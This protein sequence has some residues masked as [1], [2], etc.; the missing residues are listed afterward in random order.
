MFKRNKDI[1]TICTT[2]DLRKEIL[3]GTRLHVPLQHLQTTTADLMM[4]ENDTIRNQKKNNNNQCMDTFETEQVSK[5]FIAFP[6]K[7]GQDRKTIK[8][9]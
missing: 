2:F 8:H 4:R 7:C 9:C 6:K 1:S 5:M 3:Q